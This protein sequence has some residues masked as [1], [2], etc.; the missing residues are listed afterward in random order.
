MSTK[1]G[2]F[3]SFPTTSKTAT[4]NILSHHKVRLTNRINLAYVCK[5]DTHRIYSSNVKKV[6][7][8]EWLKSR[9]FWRGTNTS[10]IYFSCVW[11]II[12][13]ENAEYFIIYFL[14]KEE[15]LSLCICIS[16]YHNSL[17][18]W[19][20]Y[21]NKMFIR[22]I[23]ISQ[24]IRS[25]RAKRSSFR[26]NI[27]LEANIWTTRKSS[28]RGNNYTNNEIL[29]SIQKVV[30]NKKDSLHHVHV[31]S[32]HDHWWTEEFVGD[33]QIS[34]FPQNCRFWFY[35]IPLSLLEEWDR[36]HSF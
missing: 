36:K 14:P 22:I 8:N 6:V 32:T 3:S 9:N 20:L 5:P 27:Q 18:L 4:V 30:T 16:I 10:S 31:K 33:F 19:T 24:D 23:W 13:N 15:R 25:R 7:L 35:D 29:F 12:H 28:V 11:L 2:S 34:K 1:F 21:L 26:I 17:P